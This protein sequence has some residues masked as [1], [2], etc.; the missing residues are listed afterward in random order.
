MQIISLE[1]TGTSTGTIHRIVR[2]EGESVIV[3]YYSMQ[4]ILHIRALHRKV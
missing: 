2:V 4:I 3:N 1:R